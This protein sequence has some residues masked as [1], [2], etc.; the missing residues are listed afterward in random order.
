MATDMRVPALEARVH[1]LETRLRWL[2]INLQLAPDDA[3]RRDPSTIPI[4]EMELG[5]RALNILKVHWFRETVAEVAE[6]PREELLET[7][8]CGRLTVREIEDALER[9]GLKLKGV[10]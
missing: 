10:K 8:N 7:Y 9:F 4:D 1:A 2:E 6:I 3:P 5:T